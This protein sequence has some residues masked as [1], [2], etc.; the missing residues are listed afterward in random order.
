MLS[1]IS[2]CNQKHVNHGM[3]VFVI[4]QKLQLTKVWT[5]VPSCSVRSTSTLTGHKVVVGMNSMCKLIV[6]WIG[7]WVVSSWKG[8][9]EEAVQSTTMDCHKTVSVDCTVC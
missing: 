3:G 7:H 8:Q 1:Q 6:D 9:T 5:S 4:Q 2:Q